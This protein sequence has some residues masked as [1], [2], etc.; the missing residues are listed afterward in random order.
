M[1]IAVWHN[2]PSG[3]GK[4]ALYCHLRGLKQRGHAV[5]IWCP[6]SAD[7]RFLPL[8]EFGPV[9]VLP[10]SI[11][12]SSE[13]KRGIAGG[14]ALWTRTRNLLAAHR[15]HAVEVARL[16]EASGADVVL[17]NSCG[18]FRTSYLGEFT[19]LPS[20]LYLQEPNRGLFEALPRIPWT[21]I[22]PR[23]SFPSTWRYL[24]RL[25]A[26]GIATAA[27]RVQVREELRMANGYDRILVNSLFSRE[28]VLRAY[29][30]EAHVCYLGVEAE[31]FVPNASARERL[32]VSV[33]ALHYGKGADRIIQ[34]LASIPK[35]R[36]PPLVWV[37]NLVD[38]GYETKMTELARSRGVNFT[39]KQ[40]VSD[41][42]LVQ[43]LCRAGVFVYAPRLEPFGFAPLEAA[44]CGAPVVAVAEGGVRETIRDGENGI[45]AR[46][47]EPAELAAQIE[48]VL[49][50]AGLAARLGHAGRAAV[51][52]EWS[53][54]LAVERLERELVDVCGMPARG[55]HGPPP[56]G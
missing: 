44:A 18:D 9:H 4:R 3:G 52:R 8:T 22:P 31:R 34:A 54:D 21:A 24:R 53:W 1:K 2:L 12:A 40:H 48:R 35:E 51:I 30:L 6:A 28:S 23:S 50:D 33:G 27:R 11:P 16:M 39:V 5:E 32:V 47:A 26:D 55:A 19:K 7:E 49:G 15:A 37:A 20:V 29:G 46:S 14:L 43:W 10:F 45:L 36:R 41:G 56:T 42:E 17:G 25:I 38:Q 13:G